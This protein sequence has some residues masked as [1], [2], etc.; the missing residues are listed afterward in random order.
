M[1]WLQHSQ[2]ILHIIKS[3]HGNCQFSY[4]CCCRRRGHWRRGNAQW[5]TG[6][7]R[8]HPSSESRSRS[9]SKASGRSHYKHLQVTN[10]QKDEENV[11]AP[12]VSVLQFEHI[13]G[14]EGFVIDL[15]LTALQLQRAVLSVQR[16]TAEVHGAESRYR[17]PE[18]HTHTH[19]HI[20]IYTYIRTEITFTLYF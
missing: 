15:I 16:K 11:A 1:V 7:K 8:S 17:H 2:M 9:S 13:N 5:R 18:T 19:P 10:R 20:H 3:K 14:S 12:S 6:T 4:L